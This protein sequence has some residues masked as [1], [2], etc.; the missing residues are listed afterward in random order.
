MVFEISYTRKRD[1][2]DPHSKFNRSFFVEH[3][4]APSREEVEIL[5]EWVSQGNFEPASIHIKEYKL[6]AAESLKKVGM[7]VYKLDLP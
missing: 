2:A 4:S 7:P 1:P 5:V 3:D 6:F